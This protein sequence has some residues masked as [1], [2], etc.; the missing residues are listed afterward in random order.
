MVRISDARMSGTAFGT[1]VLHVAPRGG[2]PAAPGLVRDGDPHCAERRSPRDRLARPEEE[3][4]RRAARVS[5]AGSAP[6]RGY[7]RLFHE[8]VEQAPLG[9]DFDFLRP[10][11]LRRPTRAADSR[12]RRQSWCEP[13][14]AAGYLVWVSVW[15]PLTGSNPTRH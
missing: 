12:P 7:E 3:L 10:E 15:F 4:A 6:S 5:G 11:S 8:H 2:R 1:I 13:G 14:V 9:M